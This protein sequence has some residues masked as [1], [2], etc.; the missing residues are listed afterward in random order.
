MR[1]ISTRGHGPVT[2]KQAL[3]DGLAPDGGLYLPEV[4]PTFSQEQLNAFSTQSF[5]EIALTILTPFVEGEIPSTDLK[6]MVNTAYSR[7]T[8]QSITPI[9]ELEPDL[10]LLEL[11]HG[12]TLAFKD[13]ALQLLGQLLGWA[14]K[15][16]Q[17]HVTILGATSGD[18]GPAALAGVAGLPNI[19][20]V[21]LYPHNRTS[22]VQRRQMT[23]LAAENTN[24]H[25]LAIDGTFDD[26]QHIVKTLFADKNLKKTAGL[27]AINSI[28][29]AR[30]MPQMV[31]YFYAWSRLKDKN[32]ASLSFAVPTGNFGDVFAG[33][34]AKQC[35]LPMRK[36]I[37]CTN[38]N[39]IL[40][41]F[42][43]NGDYTTRPVHPTYSP[44][45]DIQV[46]SNFERYLFELF[47]RN[48]ALLKEALNTFQATGKLP[49]LT[50]E[51]QNKVQQ[52]FA[53]S[54]C[55]EDE[56]LANM[57][58]GDERYHTQLDPHTA[59]ALCAARKLPGLWPMVLL[60][61]AHGS[62]FPVPAQKAY[63]KT[64][65]LPVYMSQLMEKE[66]KY[67]CLPNGIEAG[68]NHITSQA[69]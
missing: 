2:F 37:V 4:Y 47:G 25:P 38:K 14:L 8:H 51:Q 63:G 49:P 34:L 7:F 26:C 53:A 17:Q 46:A 55:N 69:L 22:E 41:R 58:D 31:Y 28:S 13:V 11:F 43:Q 27:T 12:P 67:T 5:Q 59:T 30:L 60:S 6:H 29:W 39:D 1:Y 15:D 32:K 42:I 56:T 35:S 36:L 16:S 33:W 54:R 10:H 23:T 68:R 20:A 50:E 62:K 40:A 44:S 19:Q 64:V 66:E 45:M 24:I 52:D 61:T 48:H 57:A 3:L 21:I 18:T 65:P 9:T